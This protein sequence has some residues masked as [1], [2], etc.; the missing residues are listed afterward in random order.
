ML[1]KIGTTYAGYFGIGYVP[2]NSHL[3]FTQTDKWQ[4]VLLAAEADE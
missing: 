1:Q 3:M 2:I 4:K